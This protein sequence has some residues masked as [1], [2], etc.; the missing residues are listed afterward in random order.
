M[1]C[2]GCFGMF[3][4]GTL[5]QAPPNKHQLRVVCKSCFKQYIGSNPPVPAVASTALKNQ[6]GSYIS[7]GGVS[8]LSNANAG[9]L[10]TDSAGVVPTNAGNLVGNDGA[11]LVNAGGLNLVGQDGGT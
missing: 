11:S 9:L 2:S 10:G 7:V 6:H 8:I 4:V 3:P 5:I 1:S